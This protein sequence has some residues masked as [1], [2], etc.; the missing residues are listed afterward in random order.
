MVKRKLFQLLFAAVLVLNLFP[1]CAVYAAEP[2]VC[3]FNDTFED[4]PNY[5][6]ELFS[7][8]WDIVVQ[9]PA[10]GSKV[11]VEQDAENGFAAFRVKSNL[12]DGMVSSPVVSIKKNGLNNSGKSLVYEG[13]FYTFDQNAKLS[14]SLTNSQDSKIVE[15]LTL[16]GN[17]LS[18]RNTGNLV[19]TISDTVAMKM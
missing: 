14:L 6:G 7:K 8:H 16:K 5:G 9:E 3:H 17:E 11:T 1:V 19:T 18:L 2:A 13:L 12:K 10:T 4:Y 15:L